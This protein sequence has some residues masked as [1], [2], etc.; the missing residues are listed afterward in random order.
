MHK[1]N[2]KNDDYVQFLEY[3]ITNFHNH[4]FNINEV[5]RAIT[6]LVSIII[7]TSAQNKTDKS[8][9]IRR[10]N[11]QK[12]VPL[13]NVTQISG[14][15]NAILLHKRVFSKKDKSKHTRLVYSIRKIICT[16]LD[17]NQ[18]KDAHI[19]NKDATIS[20]LLA[21][22]ANLKITSQQKITQI[23]PNRNNAILVTLSM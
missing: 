11:P 5:K 22:N 12:G 1:I 14:D 15:T 18:E 3:I 9:Y 7:S 21:E 16:L 6:H 4:K 19:A 20:K 17:K 2:D 23:I 13:N 8:H 10:S